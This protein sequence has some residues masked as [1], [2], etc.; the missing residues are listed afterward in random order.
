MQDCITYEVWSDMELYIDQYMY[1][2]YIIW[3]EKKIKYVYYMQNWWF[4]LCSFFIFVIFFKP[5]R[6]IWEV[7]ESTRR[8][9]VLRTWSRT[10]NPRWFKK[11]Q[12]VNDWSAIVESL[13]TYENI[14][15]IEKMLC[16]K[17]R[18]TYSFTQGTCTVIPRRSKKDNNPYERSLNMAITTLPRKNRWVI[19]RIWSKMWRCW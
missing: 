17:K 16:L 18:R 7:T 11:R 10:M 19:S 1:I 14:K 4:I 13:W 12:F 8:F 2:I 6:M 3:W 9:V 15:T 5:Y